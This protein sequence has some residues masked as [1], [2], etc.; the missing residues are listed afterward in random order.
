[1]AGNQ[2]E[3]ILT[4]LAGAVSENGYA[5]TSVDSIIKLA[6]VSRRTF[7][8]HHSSKEDAFLAAFDNAVGRITSEVVRAYS[9]HDDFVE[10]ARA[11]LECCLRVLAE[12]PAVAGMVIVEVLSAGPEALQRRREVLSALTDRI[13]Q[14]SQALPETPIGPELT[15][16]TIVGA[17]LQVIYNRV[18][19]GEADRLPDLLPDLLYNVL[20]PF[21]GHRRAAE[22]RAKTLP[23]SVS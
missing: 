4:A 22:E 2:R 6:G 13:V 21:L 23:R 17:V 14:A 11:G 10:A 18:S 9:G 12:D 15:A 16:E 8:E 19:R 5:N 3:R 1:M 7:Y 20:V